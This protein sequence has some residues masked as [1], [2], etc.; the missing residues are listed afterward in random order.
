VTLTRE[1]YEKIA[2]LYWVAGGRG[3]PLGE[4]SWF[5]WTFSVTEPPR[6][7]QMESSMGIYWRHPTYEEAVARQQAFE[8]HPGEW[9]KAH[10]RWGLWNRR[11]ATEFTSG[12]REFEALDVET[13]PTHPL[14][15]LAAFLTVGGFFGLVAALLT[16]WAAVVSDDGAILTVG[17]VWGVMALVMLGFGIPLVWAR[18]Q[19]EEVADTR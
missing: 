1:T 3:Y 16:T 5:E 17:V 13:S 12:G 4:A 8:E 15:R 18:M 7:P 19:P 6:T 11:R 14:D 9:E 2:P 10:A